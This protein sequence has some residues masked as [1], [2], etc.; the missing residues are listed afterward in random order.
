M[1]VLIVEDDPGL[2]R[3]LE[4][5]L[6]ECGYAVD[7]AYDGKDGLALALLE[8][9]DVIV[10]DLLLPSMDGISVCRAAR[11]AG[12][13]TP[14]L[15]LTALDSVA[16]KIRG[17]DSGAD[18]YL[19]KPFSTSELLARLRALLRRQ[20]DSRDPLL[21]IQD[22]MLDPGTREVTRAGQ[23]IQLTNKE[24]C[25]LEYLLRNPGRVHSRDEIAA[26]IWGYDFLTQSNVVDVYVGAL[27]RKLGDDRIIRTIR[28][29]GYQLNK[30]S[31]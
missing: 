2:V 29:A 20:S 31:L 23:S 14:V 24:F 19:A 11:K 12:C 6:G 1:R 30:D 7:V 8:P 25:L 22:I 4:Q 13:N 3:V 10:L 9:Y 28:G 18:D 21:R 17:L 27:R 5:A 16:D 26:H 15:M